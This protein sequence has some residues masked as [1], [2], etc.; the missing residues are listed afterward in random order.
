ME[1]T[2]VKEGVTVAKLETLVNGDVTGKGD[3][4]ELDASFNKGHLKS[5]PVLESF[6]LSH[7]GKP[8]EENVNEPFSILALLSRSRIQ[9]KE[10]VRDLGRQKKDL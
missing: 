5:L 8:R 2:S 3:A 7:L 1:T 10:K 6:A 4:E 9:N